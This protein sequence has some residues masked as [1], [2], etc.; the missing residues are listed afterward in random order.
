MVNHL[1]A[2]RVLESG[3]TPSKMLQTVASIRKESSLAIVMYLQFNLMHRCGL[4]KF[5]RDAAQAVVD[6]VLVLDLPPEE[7]ENYEA[8]MR[9]AGLRNIYLVAPTTPESRMEKIVT[10]AAGFIYYISR[11]GVTGM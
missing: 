6:G 9:A 10:R 1:V 11:A 7:S 3:D 4:E 5:I 2:Q 8:L